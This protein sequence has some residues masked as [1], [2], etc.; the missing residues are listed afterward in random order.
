[1]KTKYFKGIG[2]S[3]DPVSILHGMQDFVT[4]STRGHSPEAYAATKSLAEI[5]AGLQNGEREFNTYC[6]GMAYFGK[7][8]LVANG[9]SP[10]NVRARVVYIERPQWTDYRGLFMVN[11]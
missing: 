2:K 3:E 1:M 6:H 4:T 10:K 7:R 5:E 11:A 9:F 8:A